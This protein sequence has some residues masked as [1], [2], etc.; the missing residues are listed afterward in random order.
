VKR[1]TG[2]DPTANQATA[3]ERSE[4]ILDTVLKTLERLPDNRA[5]Q[6]YLAH[7]AFGVPLAALA[8]FMEMPVDRARA[9]VRLADGHAGMLLRELIGQVGTLSVTMSPGLENLTRRLG[10]LTLISCL[11]C[12]GPLSF[13]S[14]GRPPRYC[15]PRCRQAGHRRCLRPA[16]E[17]GMALED[18]RTLSGPERARFLSEVPSDLA[19]ALL[20]SL[21][22]ED[23]AKA[24]NRMRRARAA[25]A[26]KTL[27]P[28]ALIEAFPWL[29][30]DLVSLAFRQHRPI[31]DAISRQPATTGAAIVRRFRYSHGSQILA[32]VPRELAVAVLC[33][34][35]T[36]EQCAML[37]SMAATR[38]PAAVA[39]F[40]RLP[41][42][43]ALRVLADMPV[44]NSGALMERM[45]AAQ[46]E[47]LLGALARSPGRA[48]IA[49][50]LRQYVERQRA[51]IR[52]GCNDALRDMR[53]HSPDE[54]GK[55]FGDIAAGWAL[56][57]LARDRVELPTDALKLAAE[58]CNWWMLYGR[59][60]SNPG[61]A[62]IQALTN[63]LEQL[64]QEVPR[65][66]VLCQPWQT[67]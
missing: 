36:S 42:A 61:P 58:V 41:Q 39:L 29:G 45:R 18:I 56:H 40:L 57:A 64:R 54:L 32:E 1:W 31:I 50:D 23:R 24:L 44:V 22:P 8:A 7:V 25:V 5:R 60:R 43:Q 26:L 28:D 65:R 3:S 14:R 2:A 30:E 67:R 66:R 51:R 16:T 38:S 6:V 35:D 53:Q 55:R 13:Q 9:I 27:P 34:L 46:A 15:S 48:E 12:G 62:P 59:H 11:A 19:A 63:L 52:A 37:G 49:D 10:V 20:S 21:P 4:M 33:C 47:R 17:T